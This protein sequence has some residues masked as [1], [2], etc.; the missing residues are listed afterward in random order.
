LGDLGGWGIFLCSEME[1]GL[2]QVILGFVRAGSIANYFPNSVIE[3]MLAGIGLTIILKQIP[4]A[5]GYDG[6]GHERMV[7]AD[8][9]FTWEYITSAFN[10]IET[11]ALIVSV[12]GLAILLMWTT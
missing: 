11:G 3:G 2:V 8:D 7:D 1:A 12:V 4:E 10:H 5:L 9:G 6:A